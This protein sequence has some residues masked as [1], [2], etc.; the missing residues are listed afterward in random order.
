MTNTPSQATAD[1]GHVQFRL[2]AATIERDVRLHDLTNE[3]IGSLI[4][5]IAHTPAVDEEVVADLHELD[6][7]LTE[8]VYFDDHDEDLRLL[9]VFRAAISTVQGV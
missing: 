4:A 9:G 3:E 8:G 1:E 5:R 2:W 6:R 7:R